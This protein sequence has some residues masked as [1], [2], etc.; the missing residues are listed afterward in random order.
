MENHP[1]VQARKAVTIYT[2]GACVPNP[3]VGGYGVVLLYGSRRRE[4]SGGYRLTTNNRM[5]VLAAIRGLE[6]LK[7]PCDVTL[8][9]DSQY[10]VQAIMKGWARRWRAQGW[11]R[12]K[13]D[14]AV[15]PDLWGRLLELC[16]HHDVHFEWV[17]GH[18]GNIENERCDALAMAACH[19]PNLPADE[20]YEVVA[21]GGRATPL[22]TSVE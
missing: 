18:A 13:T 15:N 20:A 16:D 9:T 11:R 14:L 4:L 17:K 5:E 3:G 8:F 2:D 22:L 6:A 12:T 7:E 21:T 19:V 1:L 10:L